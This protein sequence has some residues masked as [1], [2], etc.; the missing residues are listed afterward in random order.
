M[1]KSEMCEACIVYGKLRNVHEA[2]VKRT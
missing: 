2:L 1:L